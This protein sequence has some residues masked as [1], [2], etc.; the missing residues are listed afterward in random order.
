MT[1][2]LIFYITGV[3]LQA[4][5]ISRSIKL[6]HD[7]MYIYLLEMNLHYRKK[8]KTMFEN[9]PTFSEILKC[10][11]KNILKYIKYV[12]RMVRNI[13]SYFKTLRDLVCF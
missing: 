13:C 8:S 6:S 1:K 5:L 2:P 9:I 12:K 3:E 10:L 11:K 7:P 4:K